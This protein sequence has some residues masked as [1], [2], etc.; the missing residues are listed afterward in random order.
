MSV[1]TYTDEFGRGSLFARGVAR[2]DPVGDWTIVGGEARPPADPCSAYLKPT[3]TADAFVVGLPGH[4]GEG[5]SDPFPVMGDGAGVVARWVD[6]QHWLALIRVGDGAQLQQCDGGTPTV[7]YTSPSESDGISWLKLDVAG[8][9]AT[10]TVYRYNT[11]LLS[12]EDYEETLDLPDGPQGH[13]HGLISLGSQHDFGEVHVTVDEPQ[14]RTRA[15]ATPVPVRLS[16]T[17]RYI[18]AVLRDDP[19][20]FWPFDESSDE[21][22]LTVPMR[23][24]VHTGPFDL[25][26]QHQDADP[27]VVNRLGESAAGTQVVSVTAG[28]ARADSIGAF[29][30]TDSFT[31]ELWARRAY[32]PGD[33]GSGM[34][35][36][37]SYEFNPATVSFQP[38]SGWQFTADGSDVNFRYLAGNAGAAIDAG[39]SMAVGELGHFAI[40][41]TADEGSQIYRNGEPYGDIV[42]DSAE[43]FRWPWQPDDGYLEIWGSIEPGFLALYQGVLTPEQ[44]ARHYRAGTGPT[45][46][47]LH[48]RAHNGAIAEP[49][50]PTLNATHRLAHQIHMTLGEPN[51]PALTAVRSQHHQVALLD[52]ALHPVL[53]SLHTTGRIEGLEFTLGPGVLATQLD[54]AAPIG[55]G[56]V[57]IGLKPLIAGPVGLIDEFG[58]SIVDEYGNILTFD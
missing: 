23:S 13:H 25:G 26:G 21:R 58:N 12:Y 56:H 36:L 39:A 31:I 20:A 51:N 37:T 46:G 9:V 18:D 38:T 11:I 49:T 48:S 15:K 44:I 54:N 35:T 28:A 27:L 24:L 7:L 43:E 55:T 50:S 10:C 41:H 53:S 33:T 22:G 32:R 6:D 16:S 29:K 45:L 8:S 2:W 52:R 5:D 17:Q 4:G 14:S 40:A 34:I 30:A 3:G 19:I 42:A 57:P 1:V 47:A